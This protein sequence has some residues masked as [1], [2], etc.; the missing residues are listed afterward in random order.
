MKGRRLIT[1]SADGTVKIW[2]FSNGQQLKDLL[3]ADG[4][5]TVDTEITE[6]ISIHDATA[7]RVKAPSFLAVGW[8]KKLHIWPDPA[9]G[10]EEGG[11]DEE[12]D[13]LIPCRDLP[14]TG[15][16]YVQ[17]NDIMSCCFDLEKMLI[18]TG[19]VDGTIIGWTYETQFARFYLHEW[20]PTC[21]SENFTKESKSVDTL[22]VMDHRRL[23]VSMSADQM[24]RFWDLEDLAS[25]KGPV[26][27]FYADHINKVYPDQLTGLAVTKIDDNDRCVTSDTSGRIK[28]FNFAAVD[29]NSNETHEQKAAKVTNPWFVNAHRKLI[30]SVEIVEQG[31]QNFDD[32][33]SDDV[34][35]PE[36]LQPE[37]R[38]PWPDCFV[39]TAGQDWDILLHRLSNGVRIGQFAQ[40]DLWNIYDLTP[41]E[42]IKPRYVREWLAMKK[43]KWMELMTDRLLNA[44]K[45]G[46]IPEEEKVEVRLSTKDQLRQ[47]GINVNFGDSLMGLDDS[48]GDGMSAA[49][50]A[51]DLNVD[52]LES[53]DE[54]LNDQD[55]FKG[56]NLAQVKR[57]HKRYETRAER[58]A[59]LNNE[60]NDGR[61]AIA[62]KQMPKD[63]EVI[64]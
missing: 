31:D 33:E 27:K 38:I 39:L 53:E 32:D 40:D 18:F 21:T 15:A 61:Y 43:A 63:K 20:D 44:K 47:L 46:L 49:G 28:M 25:L 17:T 14:P 60:G 45:T 10:K 29:F 41:Y 59:W 9:R 37:E 30:S 1:S 64:E 52:F 51:D 35:L 8:D 26:F 19:G 62:M 6:L 22:I 12:E 42:K 36:G 34:D 48:T 16:P 56:M 2:N 24:I 11:G 7:T 54:D 5:P 50:H 58:V 55:Q 13:D 57:I 23:L 4:K 3:S